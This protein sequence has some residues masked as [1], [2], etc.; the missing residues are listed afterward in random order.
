MQSSETD[1]K[2]EKV[3][4]PN[5]Y[6]RI[7]DIWKLKKNLSTLLYG[8]KVGLS[9]IQQNWNWKLDLIQFQTGT[10]TCKHDLIQFLKLK[11]NFF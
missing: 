6:Q 11:L 2:K 8:K 1:I 4:L 3:K 10:G 9:H 5:A 7:K